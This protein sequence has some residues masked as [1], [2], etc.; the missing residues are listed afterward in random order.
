M[1]TKSLTLFWTLLAF[2]CLLVSQPALASTR[3]SADSF[4]IYV[5]NFDGVANDDI[6]LK[7]RDKVLILAAEISIPIA[8]K[9]SD[10]LL[11]RDAFGTPSIVVWTAAVNLASLTRMNADILLGDFNGDS[12]SDL[13]LKSN[14]PSV[15]SLIVYG[16]TGEMPTRLSVFDKIEGQDVYNRRIVVRD[17]NGDGRSDIQLFEGDNSAIIA[18]ASSTGAFSA[19]PSSAP[20]SGPA[21]GATA[22]DFEV[23]PDGSANYT[24]PI[25]VAPGGA[26]MQ[27]ELAFTYNSGSG[28]GYM[29]MGWDVTR[30]R[31]IWC[32]G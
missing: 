20:A 21:V 19:A 7:A 14:D 5:G 32:S 22:G 29:G 31:Q 3:F 2:A 11:I 16:A 18:L 30:Y 1:R 10:N 28:N 26:G 8:F 27:P 23:G 15:D 9:D 25:A 24:I 12:I 13:L 4:D 6:Y 17:V